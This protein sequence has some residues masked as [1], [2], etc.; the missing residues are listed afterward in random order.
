VEGALEATRKDNSRLQSEVSSLRAALRRGP[1]ADEPT[2]PATAV[3]P[4]TGVEPIIKSQ[5]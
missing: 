2:T 1:V 5:I 4:R 3:H